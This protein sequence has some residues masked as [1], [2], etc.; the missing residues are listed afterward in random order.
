MPERRE[1]KVDPVTGGLLGR[2]RNPRAILTMLG[3]A[4]AYAML[5]R[6]SL[7]LAIPPGYATAIWPPA[8]LALAGVLVG[9]PRVWPGIWLGSFLV[10]FWPTPEATSAGA[11]LTSLAIPASIGPGAATQALVGAWLVRHLVGFP[12]PLD[13]GSEIVAFLGLGGPLSCLINA[14]W[15]VTHAV[16]QRRRPLAGVRVPV[17]DMVGWGYAGGPHRDPPDADL[18]GRTPVG[19]A[20]T[21]ALGR[22]AVGAG[23]RAGNRRIREG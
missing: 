10:N 11:L 17:V 16:R 5:G 3:L 8:G 9:G 20:P 6:L 1:G 2:H 14:T 23:L 21:V 12:S 19:V 15:G 13:R 18:D 7:L 22:S 4:V